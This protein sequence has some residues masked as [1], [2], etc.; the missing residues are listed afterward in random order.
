[1]PSGSNKSPFLSFLKE[2]SPIASNF[3]QTFGDF[4]IRRKAHIFLIIPAYLTGE[5][6]SLKMF[7]SENINEYV[8]SYL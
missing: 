8:T 1:M 3:F 6:Y 5:F 4:G 7:R 2:P